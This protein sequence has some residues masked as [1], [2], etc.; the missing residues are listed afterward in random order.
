MGKYEC[1]GC[2]YNGGRPK[3]HSDHY[4][5]LAICCTWN[6]GDDDARMDGWSSI[7]FMNEVKNCQ[8][9]KDGVKQGLGVLP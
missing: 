4:Y 9:R 8:F 6:G 3:Y 7:V 5:D 1:R 2:E